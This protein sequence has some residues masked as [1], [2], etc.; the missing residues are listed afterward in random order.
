MGE[1]GIILFNRKKG[2]RKYL[3][4][5]IFLFFSPPLFFGEAF[6]NPPALRM[7]GC[8]PD[9]RYHHRTGQYPSSLSQVSRLLACLMV[10]CMV[11]TCLAMSGEAAQS[12]SHPDFH[13][14][15]DPT[16]VFFL[17]SVAF[18]ELSSCRCLS[19]DGNDFGMFKLF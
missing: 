17:D 3:S 5:S 14:R 13:G 6:T 11:I 9:P 10:A 12:R 8:A 19:R 2:E 16:I 7:S 1:N 4:L 18:M 15:F